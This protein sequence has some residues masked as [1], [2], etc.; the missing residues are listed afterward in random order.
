[1]RVYLSK[2]LKCMRSVHSLKRTLVHAYDMM[3][4]RILIFISEKLVVLQVGTWQHSVRTEI[5]SLITD[6]QIIILILPLRSCHRV[7]YLFLYLTKTNYN[8]FFD[9]A[10]DH[11]YRR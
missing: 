8:F 11:D 10:N 3:S 6:V 1:M 4:H 2:W 7:I 9:K 5:N